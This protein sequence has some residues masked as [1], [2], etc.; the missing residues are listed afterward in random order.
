M[1]DLIS[2]VIPIYKV[3]AYLDRCVQSVLNQ[4][5]QNL[6]IILVD[7]GSPD[8][9]GALCDRYQ[10]E[11][12]R[13]RV[14]HKEN[15]GLSDARNAGIDI[16]KGTYITFIDSDDYVSE[17]YVEYLYGLIREFGCPMSIGLHQTVYE[18]GKVLSWDTGERFVMPAEKC[19]ERILYH[20]VLDISAWGKLYERRLFAHVRY[21]KGKLFEDAGTTYK[22]IAQC[23]NIA[24]GFESHYYYMIRDNSIVTG[25]FSTKK[26]D[27]IE[28]TDQ[29]AEDLRKQYPA[30][31]DAILR[32]QVYARFT[33][34]RQLIESESRYPDKEKE[35]ISFIKQHATSVMH[36]KKAPKRDKFAIVTAYFGVGFF[37]ISWKLYCYLTGRKKL[38]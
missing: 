13:V 6:E 24:C 15:G 17:R 9:C 27:M 8:S 7:D 32:R 29:M 36:N 18:S 25:A 35:M 3:E 4:T 28:M 31:K 22:L 20:D 38:K 33:T 23:E 12:H 1:K 11:D 14:I 16:A 21:P 34:L 2:V 5:Y 30:L 37:R 10:A 26:L 19:M